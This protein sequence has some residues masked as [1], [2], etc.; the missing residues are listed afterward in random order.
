MSWRGLAVAVLLAAVGA[1]GGVG[2][3]RWTADEPNRLDES[4][5]VAAS[6]PSVPTNPP[7]EVLPDPSTPALATDLPTHRETVGQAPFSLSL[8]VPDGWSRSNSRPGVWTWMVPTNP[9]RTY[10]LR[11]TLPSGF[12]TIPTALADRIAALDGATGIEEFEVESQTADGFVASYVLDGYRRVT[13]ERFLSL[14][15]SQTVYTS[16]ALIGREV[17]RAGMTA[18]LDT[19]SEGASR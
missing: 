2:I 8:P 13:M 14:D 12:S 5:P 11:V 10:L 3:A 6:S 9:D 1:A 15:G 17:D 4:T 7:V 19:L 16:I 18:L